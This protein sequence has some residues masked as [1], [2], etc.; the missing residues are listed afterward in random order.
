MLKSLCFDYK[1]RIELGQNA[2]NYILKNY[3]FKQFQY[4]YLSFIKSL[5]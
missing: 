2:H 4:K 1:K 3:S 5:N